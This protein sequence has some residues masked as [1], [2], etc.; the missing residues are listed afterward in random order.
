MPQAQ[1]CIGSLTLLVPAPCL[2]WHCM[3][4]LFDLR[5][6]T[7]QL[8]FS[9]SQFCSCGRIFVD[10]DKSMHPLKSR[11]RKLCLQTSRVLHTYRNITTHM[12]LT[13]MA[14][15]SREMAW[16]AHGLASVLPDPNRDKN[17]WPRSTVLEFREQRHS[18][19]LGRV[20]WGRVYR[21]VHWNGSSLP[22]PY[23]SDR[24]QNARAFLAL[25]WSPLFIQMSHRTLS[26]SPGH[27]ILTRLL[28]KFFL[29]YF[30]FKYKF[31]HPIIFFLSFYLNSQK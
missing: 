11:S 5:D 22:E 16:I 21:S 24:I 9:F 20:N 15:P 25:P 23:A 4:Q 7:G 8:G 17:R 14:W 26:F 13:F 19:S 6:S 28:P 10:P 12:F 29:F 18:K 3:W 30:P 27:C 31:L 1:D 2:S